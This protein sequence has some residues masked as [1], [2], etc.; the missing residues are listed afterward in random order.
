M[1]HEV[2][3]VY[4]GAQALEVVQREKPDLVLLDISM[5][6]LDGREVCKQIKSSPETKEITVVMLTSRDQQFDRQV[7][8]EV[9]ADVCVAKPCS[10][11]YLE[12]VLKKLK[13]SRGE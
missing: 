7:G 3:S 8:F 1:G 11:M 2:L 4:D 13:L 9:G 5:P 12:R 10:V 6:G